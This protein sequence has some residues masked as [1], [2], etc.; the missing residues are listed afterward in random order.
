MNLTKLIEKAKD[1][2]ACETEIKIIEQ[3]SSFEEALKHPKSPSWCHWY[4][5]N[6]IKERWHEAEDVIK[7]DPEYA[8][9]YARYVI[10]KKES[11][12]PHC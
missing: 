10:G 1:A 6:V 11:T 8:Y 5:V 4:A 3:L 7:K 9:Y 2:G 12:T